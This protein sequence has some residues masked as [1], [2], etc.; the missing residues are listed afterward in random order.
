MNQLRKCR[1]RQQE[2]D[3]SC[4]RLKGCHESVESE[5]DDPS[6]HPQQSLVFSDSLPNQP[7]STYLENG[8]N[9]KRMMERTTVMG[10]LG[11]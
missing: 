7:R 8:S 9:R 3:Q 4:V 5:A 10:S 6:A 1:R 2:C 11:S